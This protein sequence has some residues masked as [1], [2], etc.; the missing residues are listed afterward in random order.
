MFCE[1]VEKPVCRKR[2]QVCLERVRFVLIVDLV[3]V[4]VESEGFEVFRLFHGV[5]DGILCPLIERIL[6]DALFLGC[7]TIAGESILL[8]TQCGVVF[9]ENVPERCQTGVIGILSRQDRPL[10]V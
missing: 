7:F 5:I 8:A 9:Y 10:I 1:L 2:L 6:I 3:S 4:D